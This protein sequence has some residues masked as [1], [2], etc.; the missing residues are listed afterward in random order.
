MGVLSVCLSVL[1]L[2]RRHYLFT[3]LSAPMTASPALQ[4]LVGRV[5]GDLLH[6]LK[7]LKNSI[8]GNTWKKVEHA[9][10]DA[11]LLL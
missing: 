11:L 6:E 4:T 8:I 2:S 3:S 5:Q 7:V 9:G 10:D 1:H